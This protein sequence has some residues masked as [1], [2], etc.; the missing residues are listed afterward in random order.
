[1][2]AP[3]HIGHDAPPLGADAAVGQI[4]LLLDHERQSAP[5]PARASLAIF[6]REGV[7]QAHQ[8]PGELPLAR[9]RWLLSMRAWAD[10]RSPARRGRLRKLTCTGSTRNVCSS[11]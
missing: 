10:P 1:V 8:V 3:A 6:V 7:V 9:A 11:R 2:G 5:T 4:V